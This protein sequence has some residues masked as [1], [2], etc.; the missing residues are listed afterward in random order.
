[1]KTVLLYGE[2]AKRFGKTHRFAVRSV[3]EAVRA[4]RANF[5]GFEGYMTAAH[6]HGIGFKVFVGGASMP[7]CAEVHNPVGNAEVIRIVPVLMGSGNV[8]RIVIGALLIATAFVTGGVSLLGFGVSAGSIG[9][10][11][12]ALI[13]GGIA[14][15]RTKGPDPTDDPKGK[16]SYAFSGSANTSR[17]GTAI[18]VG[19]GRMIV[20]SV[21]ISAGIE[22]T[23]EP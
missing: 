18:P 1:M 20:G 22:T 11:G 23:D 9:L 16:N 13:L 4:C 2:L 12:G 21:V 14:G 5:E 19:Y 7:S 6:N 3:A 17:Q 15:L 10:I 8:A